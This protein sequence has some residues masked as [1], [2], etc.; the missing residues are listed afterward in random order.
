MKAKTTLY[1]RAET[2]QAL[3]DYLERHVSHLRSKSDA[4]DYLLR[5]ALDN[6]AC[7]E[8]TQGSAAA[9]YDDLATLI[10][11]HFNQLVTL[12]QQNGKDAHRA[13]QMAE[14]LSAQLL[15]DTYETARIAEE[16]RL[17]ATARY[18]RRDLLD[19][20]APQ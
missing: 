19:A 6:T 5:V 9:A 7:G 13:A 17:R 1:L 3:A 15:N 11:Q 14:A 2:V 16:A 8:S 10:D 18:T 12:L 20:H 4:A